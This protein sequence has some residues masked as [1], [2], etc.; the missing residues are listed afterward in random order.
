MLPTVI[1]Q[2]YLGNFELYDFVVLGPFS[3]GH[4]CAGQESSLELDYKDRKSNCDQEIH[5]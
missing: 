2:G 4:K 5:L 3:N 1:C